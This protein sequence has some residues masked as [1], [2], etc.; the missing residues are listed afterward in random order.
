MS[1]GLKLP[2]KAITFSPSI[3]KTPESTNNLS[4]I[5]SL[6]HGCSYSKKIKTKGMLLDLKP[7][8]TETIHLRPLLIPG[9]ISWFLRSTGS[10]GII[11]ALLWHRM[12][13]QK[14]ILFLT[15]PTPT[16]QLISFLSSLIKNRWSGWVKSVIMRILLLKREFTWT[17]P[18]VMVFWK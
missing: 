17:Q 6:S 10:I 3:N 13:P 4:A 15:G 5:R 14:L 1:L 2:K 12:A 8:S 7:K 11:T 9:I 18:K 16:I